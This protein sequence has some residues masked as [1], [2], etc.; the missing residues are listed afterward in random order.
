MKKIYQGM[1]LVV[2]ILLLVWLGITGYF[3][4]HHTVTIKTI[5]IDQ[6]DANM[7][8]AEGIQWKE[9]RL[10]NK[11]TN[12]DWFGP[13][14]TYRQIELINKLPV[15]LI[16]K[17]ASIR[18]F[19]DK[20]YIEYTNGWKMTITGIA[21]DGK[22][23]KDQIT[24][25]PIVIIED[26]NGKEISFSNGFSGWSSGTNV[27][28]FG[29]DREDVDPDIRPVKLKWYWD[30]EHPFEVDLQDAMIE[31]RKRSFF[32]AN[33]QENERFFDFYREIRDDL[34]RAAA[35]KK[36]KTDYIDKQTI[37]LLQTYN[38]TTSQPT[39]VGAHKG[40]TDVFS[41]QISYYSGDL[42]ENRKDVAQQTLFFVNND[43]QWE[44]ID[45][46]NV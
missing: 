3:Y 8:E 15:T 43:G 24:S 12:L 36:A 4:V 34:F 38:Y 5:T 41:M 35:G 13:E 2:A 7:L 21:V 16:R 25:L 40:Y 9:I 42:Y 11:R 6:E 18:A 45:R 37:D 19:Y 30:K 31:T 22:V 26:E 44:L 27:I 20:R 23:D 10:V 14:F 28:Y 29:K 46:K 1:L 17:I 39:Y 32:A 33:Y